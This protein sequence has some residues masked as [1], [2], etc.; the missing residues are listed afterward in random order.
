MYSLNVMFTFLYRIQLTSTVFCTIVIYVVITYL[1]VS[2]SL[3][4]FAE[5]N[6]LD[7]ER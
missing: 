2:K 3:W 1:L 5:E 7:T 4:L 6:K